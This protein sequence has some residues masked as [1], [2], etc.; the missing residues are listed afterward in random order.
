MKKN[1]FCL[2]VCAATLTL[3]SSL[4][5]FSENKVAADTIENTPPQQSQ[6]S[7]DLNQIKI[8]INDIKDLDLESLGLTPEQIN[9]L[10]NS[11]SP[12]NLAPLAAAVKTQY[13]YWDKYRLQGVLCR[14]LTSLPT[15]EPLSSWLINTGISFL[16]PAISKSSGVSFMLI[17]VALKK[18]ISFLNNALTMIRFGQ[19]KGIRIEIEPN[20]GGY[21]AAYLSM[22]LYY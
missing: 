3:V 2:S 22:S 10:T 5:V 4:S 11:P 21:P 12:N 1:K 9:Q 15:G 16:G 19:A 13:I 18:R 8:P 6:E 20:P 17:N 14:S 7:D